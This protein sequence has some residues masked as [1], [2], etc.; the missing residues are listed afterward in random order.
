M[1]ASVQR[2]LLLHNATLPDEAHTPAYILEEI[3]AET[4][5]NEDACREVQDILL[6]RLTHKSPYTKIK[7]FRIIKYVCGRGSPS[8]RQDLTRRT[9]V[10]RDL[11]SFRGE[12]HPLLGDSLNVQVRKL[13]N[14]TLTTIFEEPRGTAGVGRPMEGFGAG[15]SWRIDDKSGSSRTGE[16]PA[17]KYSGFGN[18]HFSESNKGGEGEGAYA[19]YAAEAVNR[20]KVAAERVYAAGVKVLGQHA[21]SFS[22]S[23]RLLEDPGP[24]TP[25]KPAQYQP[26]EDI[27][28]ESPRVASSSSSFRATA[29]FES[30]RKSATR[31]HT[32][33]DEFT[34]LG[35]MR[36]IP[37]RSSM[38]DFTRQCA[39]LD[40]NALASA[41]TARLSKGTKSQ[42][43]VRALCALEGLILCGQPEGLSQYFLHT[44]GERAIREASSSEHRQIRE[45]GLGISRLLGLHDVDS[46]H[47]VDL[48][49]SVSTTKKYSDGEELLLDFDSFATQHPGHDQLSGFS[50]V[51][52]V[53]E[54][55][56][57]SI[58]PETQHLLSNG[59]R[60]EEGQPEKAHHE[61]PLSYLP[62]IKV[63]LPSKKKEP[64]VGSNAKR[65]DAFDFVDEQLLTMRKKPS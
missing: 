38:D 14:E 37:D 27:K 50:F 19:G 43:T 39:S 22:Q 55:T 46:P 59:M 17:K 4:Q 64:R 11:Q 9:E 31:E 10:L 42:V 48:T 28:S 63:R 57:Q 5:L 12:A 7:S 30:D 16:T 3:C 23:A 51:H 32:L 25:Y 49:R 21:T 44:E 29:M 54:V 45:R 60:I 53:E 58:I 52:P 24:A 18:P 26:F 65:S 20:A 41:I 13:A 1:L 33:V 2:R 61:D 56:Q 34:S 35:G 47:F 36:S 40:V 15:P 62:E 6:S 8:F